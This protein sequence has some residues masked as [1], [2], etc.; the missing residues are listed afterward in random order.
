MSWLLIED[1]ES[2]IPAATRDFQFS[3]DLPSPWA[4]TRDGSALGRDPVTG[5]WISYGVNTSRPQ[6][7]PVTLARDGIVVEPDATQLVYNS[8]F[9]AYSPG[10]ATSVNDATIQTPFGLGCLK[11]TPNTVSGIHGFNFFFGDPRAGAVPDGTTL[12]IQITLKPVGIYTRVNLYLLGRDNVYQIVEASLAGDGAI[13]GNTAISASIARDTDG[14]YTVKIVRNFGAGIQTPALILS[15]VN[16]AGTSRTFVGDGT[17]HFLIAYIGA[18]VGDAVTSPI[19]TNGVQLSRPADNLVARID[20][21][22]TGGLSVGIN[23]TPINRGTFTLVDASSETGEAIFIENRPEGDVFRAVAQ[24]ATSAFIT[25]PAH[26]TCT[27]RTVVG[28]AGPNHFRFAVDGIQAGA[29]AGGPMPVGI[30]TVTIGSAKTGAG[31]GA[32]IVRRIKLWDVTLDQDGVETFSEDLSTAGVA[33]FL[34]TME[35]QRTRLVTPVENS[36]TMTLAIDS[37]TPNVAVS[38]RTVDGTAKAG[39]DYVGVSGTV[40]LEFGQPSAQIPVLIAERALT[41]DRTFQF[42]IYNPVNCVLGNAVCDVVLQRVVPEGTAATSRYEFDTASLPAGWTL[43]RAS[44]ANSRNAAGLWTSVSADQPRLHY[45]APGISGLLLEPAASDQCLFNSLNP[46]VAVAATNTI[47]SNEPTP[48]GIQYVRVRKTTDATDHKLVGVFSAAACEW[49]TTN[50][51]L[52]FYARPVGHIHWKL[53]TKGIDNVWLEGR[54]NFSGAG[55]TTGVDAA[56]RAY[57]EQ[58]TFFPEWFRFGLYRTQGAT[59]GVTSEFELIAVNSDGTPALTGN[60]TEGIDYCHVQVEGA[61]G[62]SSPIMVTGASTKTARAAEVFKA[63]PAASWYKVRPNTSA[64]KFIRLRDV[65]TTQ[66]VMTWKDSSAN[67]SPDD[68]HIRTQPA[69]LRAIVKVQ[70]TTL[71]DILSPTATSPGVPQTVLLIN[72][73][74]KV[75]LF[76]NGTKAGQDT[77]TVPTA[78]PAVFRISSSEPFGES[79]MSMLLQTVALWDHAITDDDALLFSGNL[80]FIPTGPAPKPIVSVPVSFSIREGESAPLVIAKSGAGACRVSVRTSAQTAVFTADYVGIEPTEVAFAANETSKTI[81]IQTVADAVVDP[82]ETFLFRVSLVADDT[83]CE[84]GNAITTVT[85]LEPPRVDIPASASVTEGQPVTITMTKTGTGAC[86][87]SYRTIQS[88]ATVN[89]DYTGVGPIVVNFGASETTKTVQIQT[90][91]DATPDSGETFRVVIETPVDCTLGNASCTVTILEAGVDP[92]PVGQLYSTPVGFAHTDNV[93]GRVDFGVGQVPY[94]VTS[95]ADT[96]T[97]GTLRHALSAS[98]RLILFEVGGCIRLPYIGGMPATNLANVT[99]AGETAP[100]PGIILQ[101]GTLYLSRS[102]KLCVR[103]ITIERGYDTRQESFVTTN[104]VTKTMN[105]NGDA[106]IIEGSGVTRNIWIDHCATFWSND[107][108][109]QIWRDGASSG[110]STAVVENISITNTIVAEPLYRPETLTNPATGQAYK[111]HWEGGIPERDHNYGVIIGDGIKKIDMQHCL[112]GDCYWRGPIIGGGDTVVIA[113]IVSN[114][115]RLGIHHGDA[116]DKGATKITVNGYLKINGK[117][118]FTS[119]ASPSVSGMKLHGVGGT[120]YHA[121]TRV[122]AANL[123]A[124]RGKTTYPMPDTKV[125]GRNGSTLTA[126]EASKVVPTTSARPIDIPGAPVQALSQADLYN[127]ALLNVGPR[128][129]DKNAAGKHPQP[130]IQRQYDKLKLKDGAWVNH[131]S[132]VGGFSNLSQ[133]NRSLRNGTGKFKDGTTIPP[134][135]SDHTNK[136]AVRAWLR[137]FLDDVQYD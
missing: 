73:N 107:E 99:I 20:W 56:A 60:T 132:E 15:F 122:W 102:D 96:N 83:S 95:L 10:Q 64:I 106:I 28:S 90:L 137:R 112:L 77:L 108:A 109:I 36:I 76:H 124:D 119:T 92:D 43:T 68:I 126:T 85:I 103:H 78:V 65:P 57:I 130:H 94:Y 97:Q 26:D 12:G 121:D 34:P 23:Y 93:G 62:M 21:S 63:D 24:G 7:D 116:V 4:L 33:P 46:F 74:A 110:T 100:S 9:P 55:S 89:V 52:W 18:E 32:M 91:T 70:G 88:T 44:A 67:I 79:P 134:F 115:C 127:R 82:T 13:L 86:S 113:N 49:P 71:P 47:V 37:D 129:K 117:N 133:T 118:S 136:T 120:S 53:R 131:Q 1:L 2:T 11:L 3:A 58:D 54:F 128:P 19:I 48:T 22:Q 5:R 101:D 98:N 125:W 41:E 31:R 104:P 40:F 80:G 16:E 14:F 61:V 59:A 6:I 39:V 51:T 69:S 123:Y 75:S 45:H 30:N 105:S 114:N 35:V 111:G 84:L 17:S 81:T 72:D 50:A 29:D 27:A 38:Y 87:V 8:R 135:P 25:G 42:E 66:R